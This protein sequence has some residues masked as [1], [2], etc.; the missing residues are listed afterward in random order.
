MMGISKRELFEDY[1]FDEFLIVSEQ[2]VKM[3][4]VPDQEEVFIDQIGL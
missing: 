3:K 4:K 1:Y 2:Y